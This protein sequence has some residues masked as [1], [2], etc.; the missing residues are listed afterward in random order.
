MQGKLRRKYIS[1][2]P[3]ENPDLFKRPPEVDKSW[4]P[5]VI[6][7][8][9]VRATNVPIL[10]E[11]TRPSKVNPEGRV[12]SVALHE[13]Y[14]TSASITGSLR[15]IVGQGG[16]AAATYARGWA[17]DGHG[18]MKRAQIWEHREPTENDTRTRVC[19]GY[20][21]PE[22]IDSIVVRAWIHTMA[23]AGMWIDGK[24]HMF[25]YWVPGFE[26][27]QYIGFTE[28]KE[29]IKNAPRATDLLSEDR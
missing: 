27:P 20:R 18:E 11:W 8:P 10:I 4:K 5:P 19:V 26:C 1:L 13:S 29:K 14:P 25:G 21:E 17:L 7:E 16:R 23:V 12:K 22:P 3:H 28:W 2:L 6:H 24:P 9:L 15:L